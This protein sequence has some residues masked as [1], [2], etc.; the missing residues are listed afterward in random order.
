MFGQNN[1]I[2]TILRTRIYFSHLR[3]K[4]IVTML[5]FIYALRLLIQKVGYFFFIKF[6]NI[7]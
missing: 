7:F 1:E 2:N 4:K 3:K 5:S 6:N